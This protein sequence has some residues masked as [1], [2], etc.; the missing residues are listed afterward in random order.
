MTGGKIL[1]DLFGQDQGVAHQDARQSDQP[2]NRV[3]PNGWLKMSNAGTTPT[4]PSGPVRTTIAI[5]E[6]DRTCSM[7]KISIAAIMAGKIVTNASLA[8]VA[9]SIDPPSSLR[10]RPEGMRSDPRSSGDGRLPAHTLS[11]RAP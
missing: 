11:K 9:S 4:R 2:Q 1:L 7:T 6:K 10:N 8:L 3:N 5:V